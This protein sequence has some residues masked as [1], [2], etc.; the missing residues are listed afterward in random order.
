METIG[1]VG[2]MNCANRVSLGADLSFVRD[3]KDTIET[4]KTQNLEFVCMPL[5]HPR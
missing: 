1:D 3:L 5:V 2:Q 4:M